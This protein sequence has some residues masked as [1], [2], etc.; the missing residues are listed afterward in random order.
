MSKISRKNFLKNSAFGIAGLAASPLTGSA[1]STWKQLNQRDWKKDFSPNDRIHIATIGMGI[2][3]HFNTRTA[4]EI[5]G[6]EIVAAADCY[7]SRLVRANEVFGKDV[8]TTK[9]YREIL[10]RSDIDAVKTDGS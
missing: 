9:D 10:N 7:D 1:A 8:F 2:I 6:V 4:L 5:P 3:A